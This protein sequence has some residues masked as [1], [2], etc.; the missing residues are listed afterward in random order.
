MISARGVTMMAV[1]AAMVVLLGT[2]FAQATNFIYW[3]H[4][5]T[6]NWSTGSNWSAGEPGPDDWTFINNGGTAQIT[7]PNDEACSQLYLGEGSGDS[8]TVDMTGGS[9]SVGHS[10]R[11]GSLG[12]GTL[13]ITGGGVVSNDMGV[14]IGYKS[15]SIGRVK[16]EGAGST[17]T[18]GQDLLVGSHG[19]G[20][21]DITGGGAVSTGWEAFIGYGSH[22]TGAVT[23]DGTGSTWTISDDLSVGYLGT[24]TLDIT[25]GGEV[26]VED[27][28]WVSQCSGSSGTINFDNGTLTTGGLACAVDDLTG[29]GTINTGGLV[30][31]VDLVFDATHGLKRTFTIDVNPDQ[32]ITVNLDVDGSG[33]MGGGY[34]SHGTMSVSDGRVVESTAGYIGYKSGSTGAVTVEGAGSTWSIGHVLSVGSHGSGTLDITGG[35]AVS[36]YVG[37][38]G[39]WSDSTGAVTV[40]GAG[41][42]WTSSSLYVGHAGDGTLDI[43][44]G[45]TVSS[46]WGHISFYSGSTG[47]VTVRGQGSTWTN[48]RDLEVGERGDGT[49]NITGGGAVSNGY[50]NIGRLSISSGEVTVDGT[51]STWTNSGDLYVGRYGEGTLDITGGGLVIVGDTLTIDDDRDGDGF[52]NMSTGGMLA[53]FGDADDSLSDFLGLIEGADAIRYWD[54]D[55]SDWDDITHATMGVDYQLSY[56]T[57]GDL[58]GYTMLTV[59]EPATL[60][61]LAAGLVALVVRKR[62]T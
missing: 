61:L 53:L 58:S 30:S 52:I 31:D 29:T 47:E 40:E 19:T 62:R 10:V 49:L 14:A 11:V 16:V 43:T 23:L 45:G 37:H 56:L 20:T 24:G 6:G 21:L 38:I 57:A 25:G 55:I 60:A 22:S 4:T 41:S 15:G 3:Q 27:D 26:I 34:S 17:W 18:I 39:R 46:E 50:G 54:D 9:L 59:P 28:T 1:V 42:T 32:N 33:L 51:G 5:G 35:G 8:G 2:K 48:S 13:D 7:A 36:S 44:G 12:E